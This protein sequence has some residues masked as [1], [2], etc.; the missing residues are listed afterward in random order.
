MSVAVWGQPLEDM[1]NFELH[2]DLTPEDM[3]LI[4]QKQREQQERL[5]FVEQAVIA[6][7]PRLLDVP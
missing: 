7:D 6:M 2:Q 4:E 5:A 1:P 3:L